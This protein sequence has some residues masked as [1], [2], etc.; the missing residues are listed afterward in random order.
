M[1]DGMGIVEDV[2][3]LHYI[4]TG[5]ANDQTYFFAVSSSIHN[6]VICSALPIASI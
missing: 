2:T 1:I 4:F 6:D 3:D 5:L